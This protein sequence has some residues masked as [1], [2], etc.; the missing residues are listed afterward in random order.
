MKKSY[1]VQANFK[2]PEDKS[3]LQKGM[4]AEL[5]EDVAK[6]LEKAGLL[7]S[8]EAITKEEI[9]ALGKQKEEFLAKAKACEAK[10]GELSQ[11]LSGAPAP[12]QKDPEPKQEP[13]KGK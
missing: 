2:H 10:I 13:K 1:I 11:K 8:V 5:E 3:Y 4:K 12:E 6:D 7:K 9:A